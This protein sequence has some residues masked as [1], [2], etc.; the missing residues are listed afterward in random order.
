M[1]HIELKINNEADRRNVIAAL[2]SSGYGVKVTSR[3][4]AHFATDHYVQ[5]ALSPKAVIDGGTYA[6]AS[7]VLV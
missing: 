1:M 7:E 4:N 6:A 2:A 3:Q 5:V